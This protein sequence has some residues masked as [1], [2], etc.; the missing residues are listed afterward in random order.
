MKRVIKSF[1][2]MDAQQRG[3]LL[4][5]FPNGISSSDFVNFT[6]GFGKRLRVLELKTPD[7]VLLVRFERQ[8]QNDILLDVNSFE[9]QLPWLDEDDELPLPEPEPE[10]ES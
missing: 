9:D 4:Q 10:T 2:K 8:D 6:D 1:S 7:S 5:R 3:M